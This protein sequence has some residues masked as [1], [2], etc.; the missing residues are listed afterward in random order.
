MDKIRYRMKLRTIVIIAIVGLILIELLN[1]SFKKEPI[2]QLLLSETA[3]VLSASEAGISIEQVSFVGRDATLKGQVASLAEK[4]RVEKLVL[5]VWDVRVVDNQLEVETTETA[6]PPAERAMAAFKLAHAGTSALNIDG[7]VPDEDTRNRL[8]QAV[9]NAFPARTINDRLSIDADINDP[10]W[11][12][13]LMSIIPTLG[14]VDLPMLEVD[15]GALNLSGSVTAAAQRDA[16]IEEARGALSG[17]LGLNADLNVSGAAVADEDASL[18]ALRER[19]EQ[20]LAVKRIQFRINT[21]E[22]VPLSKQVLN[23]VADLLQEAPDVQVEVQGHTDNTGSNALNT[24]LSQVRADAVRTYL[25]GRGISADRLTAVGY[26]P[27]RPV[28][29][30]TTL[31]GR[32]QNRARCI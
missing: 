7:V 14:T 9:R 16:I 24:T 15:G 12:P 31:E 2:E 18:K 21:A 23:D 28:A 6:A 20:L 13:A 3:E 27:S 22:L 17:V 29:T 19:I 1:L 30:N 25:I 8:V 32:I 4:E 11:M 5:D 26:G 10:A